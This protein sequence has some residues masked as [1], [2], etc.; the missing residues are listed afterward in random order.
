M[1]LSPQQIRAAE[2]L[3]KGHS[4]QS[5]GEAVGVSRRTVLRWLKQEDFRN[6]SFGLLGRAA[7]SPQPAQPQR[8]SEE[9][10]RQ[11]GLSPQDLVEDALEAVRAILIDPEVRTCDRIKAAALI[12]QWAGLGQPAK[13][14]EME[15]IKVLVESNWVGNEVLDTLIDAGAEFEQKMKNALANGHENGHKKALLQQNTEEGIVDDELDD[16]ELDDDE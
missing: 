10:R 11:S 5:V 7:Q 6:L 8:S 3:S 12:G 4:Q 15:A 16:D 9:R 1:G 14:V 2:L 13:M